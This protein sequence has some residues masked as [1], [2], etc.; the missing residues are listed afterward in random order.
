VLAEVHPANPNNARI[1]PAICND[2]FPIGND[3][4]FANFMTARI[5]PIIV[6]KL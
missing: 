4:L 5:I 1:T 3:H 2:R 6:M